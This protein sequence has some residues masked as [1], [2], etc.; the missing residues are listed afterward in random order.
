MVV[1]ARDAA[2]PASGR[3][4]ISFWLSM[5]LLV[6]VCA[7]PAVQFTGLVFHEWLGLAIVSARTRI[8][9]LLNLSL[10]AAITA[11]VYSGILISRQAIPALAVAGHHEL[12]VDR[13][14]V[15]SMDAGTQR[16][17]SAGGVP[18]GGVA[19]RRALTLSAWFFPFEGKAQTIRQLSEELLCR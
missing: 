15:P 13:A 18:S 11:V 17:H 14:A 19:F 16:V 4:K 1:E 2:R 10:F 3:L 5:T 7:L 9:Y 12:A 8:N 6:S